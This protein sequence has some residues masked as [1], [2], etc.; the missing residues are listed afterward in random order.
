MAV[1]DQAG[2]KVAQAGRHEAYVR[3][4]T[5]LFPGMVGEKYLHGEKKSGSCD[6]DVYGERW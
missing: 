5:V 2:V 4:V 3:I 1:L 6:P